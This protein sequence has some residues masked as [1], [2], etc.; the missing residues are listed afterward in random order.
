MLKTAL[1]P[2]FLLAAIFLILG[3]KPTAA[4]EDFH[5]RGQK[6]QP[7]EPSATL[8]LTPVKERNGD[9]LRLDL[10]VDPHEEEIN[11]V[12]AE[13]SFPAEKMSLIEMGKNDSFCSFFIEEKIDNQAGRAKISCSVPYPGIAKPGNVITLIFKKNGAGRAELSL[14]PEAE[15]LANDG[16]GTNVLKEL[17]D[18]TIDLE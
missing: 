1:K 5:Y 12:G 4:E 3:V 2:L 11:A 10:V 18:Q 16:Y 6:L 7:Q 17:K 9:F 15:V 14:R 8:F 13:I